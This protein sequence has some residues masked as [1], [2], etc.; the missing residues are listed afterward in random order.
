MGL[1]V[2]K[3]VKLQVYN[4]SEFNPRKFLDK[5]KKKPFDP[6]SFLNKIKGIGAVILG[7]DTLKKHGSDRWREH[8]IYDEQN[9]KEIKGDVPGGYLYKYNKY[10]KENSTGF[11]QVQK[12]VNNEGIA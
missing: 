10:N 7:E 5:V 2:M 8:V 1:K 3:C 11:K 6:T 12:E 4:M 9:G